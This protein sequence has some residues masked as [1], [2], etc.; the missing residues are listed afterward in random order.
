MNAVLRHVAGGVYALEGEVTVDTIPE[1]WPR[2]AAVVEKGET[3]EVSCGGVT[4]ADTAA[5]ACLVEWARTARE[6]GG[7]LRVRDLPEMMEVIIDVCDIDG[8]L[9]GTSKS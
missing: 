9:T 5:V 7:S 8:I 4:R 3:A 2:I 6:A 1:L